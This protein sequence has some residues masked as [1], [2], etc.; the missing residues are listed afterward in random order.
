M[1]QQSFD[2]KTYFR[3]L[4][5]FQDIQ[6]QAL[7]LLVA[8][9]LVRNFQK[10]EIIFMEGTPSQGMYIVEQGSV[11]IYKMNADG[12]EKTIYI[13]GPGD[14]FNE[15][16]VFD[17]EA[18]P[19]YTAA[20]SDC[21][22]WLLLTETLEEAMEIDPMLARRIMKVLGGRI[23]TLVNQIA[24]L[25]LYSVVVRLARFLCQQAENPSLES[26][27]ITRAVIA[28][29]LATTPESISRALRSLENAEAIEFDRHRIRI[30]DENK[31]R[32]IASLT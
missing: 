15:I 18:N 12:E 23:R 25:T 11:R 32:E 5:Y 4:P 27:A 14:T 26:P 13:A 21:R 30:V 6:P 16:S 9:S 7:E 24:D 8:Q 20:L 3:N 31:L 17:G 29:Y 22:L 19:A 1:T 2:L 10:D 28:S